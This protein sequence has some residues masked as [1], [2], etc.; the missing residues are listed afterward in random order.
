MEN[1]IENMINGIEMVDFNINP[2]IL[3]DNSTTCKYCKY[4]DI[5]FH[6]FNDYVDLREG[7]EDEMDQ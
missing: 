7:D 6:T 3:K 5:C 4:K 2:K 1:N